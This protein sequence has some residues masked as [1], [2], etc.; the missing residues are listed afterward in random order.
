MISCRP[1]IRLFSF[2]LL[3]TESNSSEGWTLEVAMGFPKTPNL[4][5]LRAFKYL[6]E[7]SSLPLQPQEP[8]DGRFFLDI[9]FGAGTKGANAATIRRGEHSYCSP[10]TREVT[11]T[12]VDDPVTSDTT[13]VWHDQY[14]TDKNSVERGTLPTRTLHVEPAKALNVQR[15]FHFINRA[16][17]RD[18]PTLTSLFWKSVV[19]TTIPKGH[20]KHISNK[21][22]KN[23]SWSSRHRGPVTTEFI[24]LV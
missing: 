15:L 14:S 24:L 9:L 19:T 18:L 17:S 8:Q 12:D 4:D 10:F 20:M 5:R 23:G 7:H 21:G 13:L 22:Q 1:A 6:G 11:R 16:V 2:L 3:A